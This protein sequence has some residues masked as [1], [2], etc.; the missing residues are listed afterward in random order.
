[1]GFYSTY[2]A[3]KRE[4]RNFI[5]RGIRSFYSTYEALK[6]RWTRPFFNT[7]IFVFTLPMRHWNSFLTLQIPAGFRSVFT[8]P[9]RHWNPSCEPAVSSGLE[10]FTLPMRHWNFFEEYSLSVL[11]VQFLL[12]LWGI[13]TWASSRYHIFFTSFYST[14]EA[15]KHFI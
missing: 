11:I 13:E 8:L 2:E 6:Q 3:L 12:Y 9:M 10:V 15:L 14:Y 5:W 4:F 7:H 1:M